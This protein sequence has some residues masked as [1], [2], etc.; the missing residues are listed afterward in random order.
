VGIVNGF[1]TVGQNLNFAIAAKRLRELLSEWAEDVK[2]QLQ[3]P[4]QQQQQQNQPQN[5][6][7]ED[8]TITTEEDYPSLHEWVQLQTRNN[9]TWWAPVQK[10]FLGIRDYTKQ[11]LSYSTTSSREQQQQQ[12]TKQKHLDTKNKRSGRYCQPKQE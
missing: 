4:Q 3:V 7:H 2:K 5:L 10:L 12:Q 11:I 6:S 8:E 9:T 1:L